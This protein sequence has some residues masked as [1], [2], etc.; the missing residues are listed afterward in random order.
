MYVLIYNGFW[1]IGWDVY[2][3]NLYNMYR[4]YIIWL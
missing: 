1:I 4:Y 3:E 2:Y